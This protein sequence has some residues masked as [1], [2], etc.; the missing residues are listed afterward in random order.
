MTDSITVI[1]GGTVG[2]CAALMIAVVF[3]IFVHRYV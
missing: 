2:A 3:V 1:I